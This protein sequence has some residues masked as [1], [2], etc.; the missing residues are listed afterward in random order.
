MLKQHFCV[1]GLQYVDY[2]PTMLKDIMFSPQHLV[3]GVWWHVSLIPM[4]RKMSQ[5]DQEFKVTLGYLEF[6]TSLDHMTP[7]L[8][9]IILN[10]K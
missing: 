3:P 2:L 9:N 1:L 10:G 8:N 6:V 4:V 7:C 5:E